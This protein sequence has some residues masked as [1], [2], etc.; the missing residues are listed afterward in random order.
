MESLRWSVVGFFGGVGFV[1]IVLSFV[2]PQSRCGAGW[3]G[4]GPGGRYSSSGSS[5]LIRSSVS[6][7]CNKVPC[8]ALDR[9]GVLVEQAQVRF[10][11][12]EQ[13]GRRGGCRRWGRAVARISGHR[14]GRRR[15]QAHGTKADA[16]PVHLGGSLV[17][18]QLP[19]LEGVR[20]HGQR[21]VVR[22]SGVDLPAAWGCGRVCMTLLRCLGV[23]SEMASGLLPGNLA[24]FSVTYFTT[25]RA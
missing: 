10:H 3:A 19:A 8:R 20:Q 21:W 17:E 16:A 9:L 23:K 11:L 14:P 4:G 7:Q 22:S 2:C 6:S 25:F 13:T 18:R 15:L 12:L 1:A 5:R 24:I